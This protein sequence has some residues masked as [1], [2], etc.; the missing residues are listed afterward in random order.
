MERGLVLKSACS[1]L[2]RPGNVNRCT[3]ITSQTFLKITV[4]A[5]SVGKGLECLLDWWFLGEK[6]QGAPQSGRGLNGKQAKQWWKRTLSIIRIPHAFRVLSLISKHNCTWIYTHICMHTCVYIKSTL[7]KFV[8]K[9]WEKM[10]EILIEF[11]VK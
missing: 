10:W 4:L 1:T 8:A 5:R 2:M 7:T 9:L 11:Y 6:R 3:Q